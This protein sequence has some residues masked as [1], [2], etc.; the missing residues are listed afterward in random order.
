M[1]LGICRQLLGDRHDAEDAFQAAFLVLARRAAS[2]RDPDLL[3]H[4]LYG[5]AMHT[6]RNVRRRCAR[7]RRADERRAMRRLEADS[8]RS[9]EPSAIERE[10]AEALHAEIERLPAT[11][12]LPVVL[13]Y[14]EGLSLA[15]AAERLR[16]PAGT[17]HSRLDR[18]REKLRR[19]LTRRGIALSAAALAA[20][21]EARP[22]PASVPP[23]LCDSTA[24]AATT[25]AARHAAGG[26]LS[27]Q[28]AALA[29]E[30][31]RNMI[32]H[33]LKSVALAALLIATLATGAASLSV[34][35]AARSREGEPPGEPLAQ[36]ART[37]PR[38]PDAP[39]PPER[40]A[41]GR[42]FV[43]GR[44]LDPQ[45]KPIAGVA[46][47]VVG[48]PRLP[49]VA[50]RL[51]T[52]RRVLIGR[53]ET[54]SDGRFRFD[55]AR[56]A[57]TRFFEVDAVA[58]APGFG[59][60]WARLNPDA[61]QPAAEI[62]LRP[63][64]VVHARVVDINGQ[65]AVGVQFWVG[66]VGRFTGRGTFEGVNMGEPPAPEGLRAWPRPVTTD[67]DGRL[68]LAGVDRGP[69]VGL[70]A[71]DPRFA[72]Q[73]L[74]VQTDKPDGPKEVTLV[75][76][77]STIIEG[78]VL[79]ADT[80]SP[81]PDA[82]IS[83]AASRRQ[84]D[85][86]YST[87]FRADGQGR[88][89][90]NPS[91]GAYFRVDA[92]PPEGQPYLILQ[93]E[94]AWKTGTVQRELDIRL[95]R[96]VLIRGQVTDEKTGHPV[97]GA[98]VQYLAAR[99]PDGVIDGWQAVVASGDDGS[100]EIA[101]APGKGHLFV[102]G[103]TSDYVLESIGSNEIYRGQPGGQRYYA[104]KVIPYEF[105]AGDGPGSIAVAL[106][107]GEDRQGAHRRSAGADRSTTPRS[108]RSCTCTTPTCDGGAT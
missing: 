56:T 68:A 57:S 83:V 13:C 96:G 48:R 74:N 66:R 39:R 107:S 8:A 81:I 60:G 58:A 38:R 47:D 59:V 35:A 76:R 97:A 29:R 1:V 45:G 6:A 41:P 34:N 49:W 16:C 63:E 7:A 52:E 25:F 51:P 95:P 100:Y 40:P 14:L 86:M 77:P 3:A 72:H 24:R 10:R 44:V 15:E 23:L 94:F 54:G 46:I 20:A 27:A 89:T 33:Q 91:P 78:R 19:G 36:T 65:P 55:A 70:V 30:V 80:G 79:A 87:Q 31:L 93:S 67:R 90:A 26:A 42:M 108:S 5:V 103:P 99:T 50:T 22:A 32:I 62:T 84:F 21:L 71:H 106:R 98:S 64:Q 73:W 101:V 4:W 82:A 102:Y 69:S 92:H 12:R 61:E 37:E 105:P 28:A 2:I 18:A 85:S 11:T 17:V 9:P 88:Y 43:A 104:H 53:G 75:L